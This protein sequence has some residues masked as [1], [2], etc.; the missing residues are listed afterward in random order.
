MRLARGAPRGEWLALAVVY[1]SAQRKGSTVDWPVGVTN[2]SYFRVVAAHT[3]AR[4]A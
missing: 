3:R 2:P 1:T 4:A